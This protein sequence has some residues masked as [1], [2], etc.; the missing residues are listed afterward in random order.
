MQRSAAHCD[1]QVTQKSE[2]THTLY[3]RNTEVGTAP[4]IKD[5]AVPGT[6]P[7]GYGVRKRIGIQ[8]NLHNS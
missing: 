4:A 5:K 2:L 7:P 3:S 1:S 8:R 6:V